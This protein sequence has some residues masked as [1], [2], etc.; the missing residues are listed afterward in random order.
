[1]VDMVP[2][3]DSDPAEAIETIIHEL[4]KFS[5]AL[6]MRERWLVLNKCDQ[7]MEDEQQALLD[8]VVERLEW[9]GPVYV[10][11]ASERQGTDELAKDVMNWLDERTQRMQD[12]E[13]Y[14]AQVRELD[15]QI[16]DEA[17]AHI[18]TLDDRKAL[19]KQG[20]LNDA[21]D[22]DDDEDDEDGPEII[23]VH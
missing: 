16:E 3:D 20:L 17:R 18:Q 12:D 8:D 23:Y 11:S 1:M 6:T 7:L 19:R 4:G 2:P 5:P 15:Q 9:D 13:E 14:A 21:D 22:E 10:V